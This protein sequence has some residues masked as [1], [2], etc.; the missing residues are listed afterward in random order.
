MIDAIYERNDVNSRALDGLEL[1]KDYYYASS[2]FD[3]NNKETIITENGIKYYVDY[4]ELDAKQGHDYENPYPAHCHRKEGYQSQFQASEREP[5]ENE[6]YQRAGP[7]DIVEVVWQVVGKGTV[8]GSY[9]EAIVKTW[10]DYADSVSW[11]TQY[12]NNTGSI[13]QWCNILIQN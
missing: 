6:D 5:Q 12:I 9:V 1:Y 11:N 4:V 13:V 8:K 10:L 7:A 2:D 3:I